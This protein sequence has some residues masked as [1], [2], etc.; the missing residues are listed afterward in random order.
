[1][2]QKLFKKFLLVFF[3]LIATS[4]TLSD[5]EKSVNLDIEADIHSSL[6]M[7]WHR[8]EAIDKEYIKAKE[9]LKLNDSFNLLPY[10]VSVALQTNDKNRTVF[11]NMDNLVSTNKIDKI[12]IDSIYISHN[13]KKPVSAKENLSIL[14]PHDRGLLKK[15][16]LLF[17]VKSEPHHKPGQYLAKF[18]FV[19]NMLP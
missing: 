10:G 16:V 4:N 15:H 14:K 18:K 12:G 3:G 6:Q 13:G 1:M 2:T 5:D 17:I 11:F 19:N 7:Q 9:Q 8:I